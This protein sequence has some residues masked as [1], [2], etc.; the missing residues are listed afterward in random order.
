MKKVASILASVVLICSILFVPSFEA[1]AESI[2]VSGIPSEA[3]IGDT[4]TMSVTIPQ[5]IGGYV[6]VSYST[7][8]LKYVSGPEEESNGLVIYTQFFGGNSQSIKFEVIGTGEA[9]IEVYMVEAEYSDSA[10]AA[11]LPKVTKKI[12]VK[13]EVSSEVEPTKSADNSLK[14]LKLTCDTGKAVALSPAFQK[15]TT[16]YTATVDYDVTSIIIDAKLSNDKAKIES[17]TGNENLKVGKNTISIIVVAENGQKANY[18]IT[19]TRNEPVEEPPTETE[20]ETEVP[21]TPD[22]EVNGEGVQVTVPENVPADFAEKTVQ[23]A[24]GKEVGAY[25]LPV[26]NLTIMYLANESGVGAYYIYDTEEKY[27]YPFVKLESGDNYVVVL[28]AEEMSA[29]EGYVQC[30]LSIE[31]KGVVTAYQLQTSRTVDAT[32]F[33]LIY[34]M[35]NKGTFG[36]YQYDSG[37]GTYQRCTGQILAGGIVTPGNS[38]EPNDTEGGSSVSGQLQTRYEEMKNELQ[39]AKMMLLVTLCAA[40]FIIVVLVIIIVVLLVRKRQNDDFGVEEEEDEVEFID[41]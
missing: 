8:C 35:N 22:M 26:G 34:C 38:E 24:G 11:N 3:K 14:S 23:L 32:D 18:R 40:A 29:P 15:H 31:G 20:T 12:S 5:N 2:T 28:K 10:T 33:Y 21:F 39:R 17:I 16:K 27:V 9:T 19:L 7:S 30:T 13:N 4:F 25:T 1:K 6:Y 36:W 37:E 41:M